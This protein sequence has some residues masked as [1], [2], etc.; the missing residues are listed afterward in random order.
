MKTL[1]IAGGS[2]FL[3]NILINH[4]KNKVQNIYILSRSPKKNFENVTHL[5]WD[6]ETR[7]IWTQVLE[8]ADVLINLTGKSVDCRY[9]ERNKKLILNSRVNSTNIL[10]KVISECKH[11]PK[12]WLNS[13]TATI[14][15]HSL[16]KEM[17][18]IDGEIGRGFSVNV[19]T[20]WEKAF[21]EHNPPNTRQVALRTSIVFGKDGGAF[22]PIKKLTQI[23]FGGKQGSGDQKVSWIHAVDFA[24]S[25]AFIIK[26]ETITG[27]INIVSPKPTNNAELMQKL[28]KKTGV[29]FGIPMSESLLELGAKIINTETEL[30][31]K[32]RNVIPEK[33][34][35]SGFNFTFGTLDIALDN[36]LN[37]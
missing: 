20:A 1:V 28:R 2:G 34:Q 9:N 32:S 36:L 24:R 5:I 19:A 3:G 10:G 6:A 31:L 29:L 16:N 4:F 30:I 17:G 15:R 33:L 14:Y 26:N 35:E 8:G 23:G 7:D 18:E 22:S 13:S 21:F 12:I 37:H 11:P 27:A 25:I